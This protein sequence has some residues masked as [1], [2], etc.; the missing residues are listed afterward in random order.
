MDDHV[1]EI[2][3]AAIDEEVD[4]SASKA[5]DYES[6]TSSTASDESPAFDQESEAHAK[7]K[8]P[9]CAFHDVKDHFSALEQAA[10]SAED[11]DEVLEALRSLK[12][13]WWNARLRRPLKQ[14]DVR[15]FTH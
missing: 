9:L 10:A 13:A 8:A 4:A 5:V 3:A 15:Q 6:E 7:V 12:L 2:T 11:A 1:E 14:A